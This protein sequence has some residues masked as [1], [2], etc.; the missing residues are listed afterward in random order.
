M[1]DEEYLHLQDVEKLPGFGTN[2]LTN[3]I[4]SFAPDTPIDRLPEKIGGCVL[5][6]E[7]KSY[8]SNSFDK[9]KQLNV[10]SGSGPIYNQRT[11]TLVCNGNFQPEMPSGTRVSMWQEAPQNSSVNSQRSFLT[12]DVPSLTV[13]RNM[14]LHEQASFNESNP[15]NKWTYGQMVNGSYQNIRNASLANALRLACLIADRIDVKLYQLASGLPQLA[16]YNSYNNFVPHRDSVKFYAGCTEATL[17]GHLAFGSPSDFAYLNCR[18]E[19]KIHRIFAAVVKEPNPQKHDVEFMHRFS[20]VEYQGRGVASSTNGIRLAPKAH[21][22][23][24]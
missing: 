8:S 1:S 13:A 14:L 9:L 16:C 5:A 6:F 21:Y 19:S 17:Q 20:N 18:I 15:D 11:G 2:P 22:V 12:V 3:A 10:A 23:Q 24:Q 4:I 7:L